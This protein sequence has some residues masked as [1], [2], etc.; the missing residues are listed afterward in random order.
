MEEHRGIKRQSLTPE[1]RSISKNNVS[2]LTTFLPY[3]TFSN[4]FSNFSNFQIALAA[5]SKLVVSSDDILAGL[6]NLHAEA[7]AD[8]LDMTL[9][10]EILQLP[11]QYT[12][13]LPNG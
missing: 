7:M 6:W 10:Y 12:R 13:I 3:L 8:I 11:R 5:V 1:P 9:D 2:F 4:C